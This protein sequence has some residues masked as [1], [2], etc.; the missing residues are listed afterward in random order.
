MFFIKIVLPVLVPPGILFS[1]HSIFLLPVA[2]PNHSFCFPITN[3]DSIRW[4]CYST[5]QQ[6]IFTVE[7]FCDRCLTWRKRKSDYCALFTIRANWGSELVYTC[8][9]CGTHEMSRDTGV[10][11]PIGKREFAMSSLLLGMAIQKFAKFYL[12]FS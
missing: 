1:A 12:S 9:S 7:I 10:F 6:C 8:S 3:I 5:W 11:T 4:L 2:D